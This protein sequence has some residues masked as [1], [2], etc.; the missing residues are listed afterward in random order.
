MMWFG[1]IYILSI[2]GGM[3]FSKKLFNDVYF[4]SSCY[5]LPIINTIFLFVLVIIYDMYKRHMLNNFFE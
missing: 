4:L 1:I 3:Y 5:F 2:I